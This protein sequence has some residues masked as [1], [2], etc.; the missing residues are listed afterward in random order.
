MLLLLE[1]KTL[2]VGCECLL[3]LMWKSNFLLLLLLLF[4]SAYV[5]KA[6][7]LT[8]SLVVITVFTFYI[9]KPTTGVYMKDIWV[10][11]LSLEE[12]LLDVFDNCLY[13]FPHIHSFKF[14]IIKIWEKLSQSFK[15]TACNS[16]FSM[17]LKYWL[18]LFGLTEGFSKISCSLDFCR[19]KIYCKN[20][21]H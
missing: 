4:F 17:L 1:S 9:K 8:V 5:Q 3:R 6:M 11:R 7:D 2:I 18:K 14:C 16:V 21:L 13:F 10:T 19:F 12:K 15:Q 20:F